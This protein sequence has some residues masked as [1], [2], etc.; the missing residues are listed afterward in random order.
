MGWES[1]PHPGLLLQGASSHCTY[2]RREMGVL[3][4][5]KTQPKQH[6]LGGSLQYINFNTSLPAVKI[7]VTINN[8]IRMHSALLILQLAGAGILRKSLR[9]NITY[10][11]TQ[12][13]R[14]LFNCLNEQQTFW[15]TPCSSDKNTQ[16]KP[17]S[18]L[19]L[20]QIKYS[21]GRNLLCS[22]VWGLPGSA[23][24]TRVTARWAEQAVRP[25]I[26]RTLLFI[27]QIVWIKR[28]NQGGLPGLRCSL[29]TQQPTPA[30]HSRLGVASSYRKIPRL[31][32]ALPSQSRAGGRRAGADRAGARC[33]RCPHPSRRSR[34]APPPR[35][36]GPSRCPRSFLTR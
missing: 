5:P 25:R 36:T 11:E 34:P 30:V 20:E 31:K 1:L 19:S 33:S 26:A 10:K 4:N 27:Y 14:L 23:V 28:N 12:L 22:A 7:N 3:C 6:K 9:V 16:S 18:K 13:A 32:A 24:H 21:K 35:H 17:N 29:C 15:L 8:L 2:L